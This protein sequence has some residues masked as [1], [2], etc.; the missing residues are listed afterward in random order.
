MLQEEVRKNEKDIDIKNG[1]TKEDNE[2]GDVEKNIEML[3]TP[4]YG[5]KEACIN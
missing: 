3:E 1:D 2:D 5:L 4:F